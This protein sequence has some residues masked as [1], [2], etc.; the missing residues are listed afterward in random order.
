[1]KNKLSLSLMSFFLTACASIN[2]VETGE[3]TNGL[4][5]Y[6]PN[7]DVLVT[8]TVS[9]DGLSKDVAV[10]VTPAYPDTTNRYVMQYARNLFGKNV[11]DVAINEK[12]LLSSARSTTTSSVS[13][14]FKALAAD[15]AL[16][17]ALDATA[18]QKCA[19]KGKKYT[20]IYPITSKGGDACG[21]TISIEKIEKDAGKVHTIAPGEQSSGVY[22]RQH[23]PYKVKV[24]GADSQDEVIVFSPSNAPTQFLPISR[25]FF[26]NNDATFT[27]EDGSPKTYKQDADSE[28]LALLKLPAD[29]MTAYF[30]AI[31][32][33]F[34]S[35]KTRDEKEAAAITEQVKL[36]LA[37]R[38]VT[39][40]LAAI[41]ANDTAL[42]KQLEC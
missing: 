32:S 16:A 18:P 4:T 7:K 3:P 30:T 39:S 10:S 25:T 33:T 29:V 27:F 2:S 17:F 36:E 37:K 19:T 31:G 35:F 5:Y 42:I 22:Y 8:V 41:K 15:R 38:K 23:K 11:L 28:L 24:N 12:G 13:E 1:M 26:A 9:A 20:F 6:M 34:D 40:C 21:I 14:I